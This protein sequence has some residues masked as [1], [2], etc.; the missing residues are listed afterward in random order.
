MSNVLAQNGTGNRTF[1]AH[2]EIAFDNSRG[3]MPI[4]KS[5]VRIRRVFGPNK[6][7]FFVNGKKN[8]CALLV[9]SWLKPVTA[10]PVRIFVSYR[11]F[12]QEG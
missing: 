8:Q 11:A 12:K 3:R 10:T 2:V 5:E 9:N 6:D 4:K 7:E 1:T